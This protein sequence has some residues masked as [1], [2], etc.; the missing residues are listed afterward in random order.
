MIISCIKSAELALQVINEELLHNPS[1]DLLE[2]KEILENRINFYKSNLSK[3][4]EIEN[5]LY[6][7]IEYEGKSIMKAVNEVADENYYNDIKP[8]DPTWIFRKYLKNIR[9]YLNNNETTI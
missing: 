3:M 5:R 6:Y 1:E 9:K 8:T 2:E 7:K 4:P